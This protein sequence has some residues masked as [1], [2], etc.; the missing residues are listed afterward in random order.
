MYF[1]VLFD[2]T[3]LKCIERYITNVWLRHVAIVYCNVILASCGIPTREIAHVTRVVSGCSL[4]MCVVFIFL[5]LLV[6]LLVSLAS[7]PTRKSLSEM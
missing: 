4:S 1:S 7:V 6:G 2:L 5:I 3:K